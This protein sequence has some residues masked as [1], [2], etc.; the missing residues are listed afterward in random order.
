MEQY[1]TIAEDNLDQVKNT[2]VRV[3][4]VHGNRRILLSIHL[5][6][7]KEIISPFNG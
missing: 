6:Q 7:F 5:W 1:C 3:H 4:L 2:R